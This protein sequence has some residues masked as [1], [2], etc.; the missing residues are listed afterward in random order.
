[1]NN[2]S[3][4]INKFQRTTLIIQNDLTVTILRGLLRYVSPRRVLKGVKGFSYHLQHKVSTLQDQVALSDKLYCFFQQSRYKLVASF[5]S[6]KKNSRST[7]P[8]IF[9]CLWFKDGARKYNIIA[10]PQANLQSVLSPQNPPWC[11]CGFSSDLHEFI[12]WW[13]N[14]GASGGISSPRWANLVWK[15][16]LAW[17]MLVNRSRAG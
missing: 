11:V 15:Q 6:K 7:L 3:T 17:V 8:I 2:F 10:Q 12:C 13:S 9:K 4:W 5:T 1:M 16:S 14:A